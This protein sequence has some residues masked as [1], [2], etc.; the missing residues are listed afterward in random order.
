[1]ASVGLPTMRLS[2]AFPATLLALPERL[3]RSG[4]AN[5]VAGNASD[6]VI[7]GNPTLANAYLVGGAGH[8]T[9]Y[10]GTAADLFRGDAGND[11]LYS[12]GGADSFVYQAPGFGYDQVSGFTQGSA[13]LDFRGSGIAFTNLFLNSAGGNTQV[14]VFGSAILVFGVAQM[15]AGD[16]LF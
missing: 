14:E 6:N 15:S 3:A 10:G 8:D 7:V 16:F 12:G 11:V 9:I 1:M 2:E 5:S 13:K 4:S